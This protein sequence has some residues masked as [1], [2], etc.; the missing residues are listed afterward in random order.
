MSTPLS[1]LAALAARAECGPVNLACADTLADLRAVLRLAEAAV[2]YVAMH[3]HSNL[4]GR[5]GLAAW[6]EL[7]RLAREMG[8]DPG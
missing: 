7:R 1:R 3:E 4:G 6:V 2:R 8:T 5:D